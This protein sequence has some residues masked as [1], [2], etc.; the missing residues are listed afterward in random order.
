MI[1][2][3]GIEFK[4]NEQENCPELVLYIEKIDSGKTP[5]SCEYAKLLE[6]E[7]NVFRKDGSIEED[8]GLNRI[9]CSKY[10]EQTNGKKIR[11]QGLNNPILTLQGD[12]MGYCSIADKM[13]FIKINKESNNEK[14]V[15]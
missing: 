9:L 14:K 15:S 12:I 1:E 4:L 13:F 6:Q 5:Y 7:I 3:K 8:Y 11:C 10:A 2:F